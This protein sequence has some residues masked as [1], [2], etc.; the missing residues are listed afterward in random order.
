[1]E[2]DDILPQTSVP[3]LKSV[4]SALKFLWQAVKQIEV[5]QE[6]LCTLVRF[7]AQLLQTL[8]CDYRAGRALKDQRTTTTIDDFR[9]FVA[10]GTQIEQRR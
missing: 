7:G 4:F 9:R 5:S 6:Q 3:I 10:R 1:M 2:L 8:D